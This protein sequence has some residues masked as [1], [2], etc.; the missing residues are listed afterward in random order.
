[1]NPVTVGTRPTVA[2]IGCGFGGV[3]TIRE[4]LRRGSNMIDILAL[5][6]S[7]HLY[8][9]PI[10]PRT[11]FED[12]PEH[13]VSVPLSGLLTRENVSLCCQRALK[14]DALRNVIETESG[15][16]PF[17]YCV[18]A[19]GAKAIPLKAAKNAPLFYPK[20]Q[21]HLSALRNWLRQ[22]IGDSAAHGTNDRSASVIRIAI[23]G[24]GLSGVEFAVALRILVQS[25]LGNRRLALDRVTITI[26]E[27]ENQIV[28]ECT[29]NLRRSLLRALQRW[30]VHVSLNHNATEVTAG[31]L[32]CN[33]KTIPADA[34]L[35]CTGSK[36]HTG[37]IELSGIPLH[38]GGILV[39]GSMRSVGQR[40]V[41][42]VGDV[43]CWQNSWQA[44][45]KRASEAVRQGRHVAHEIMAL[46][47]GRK[48]RRYRPRALTGVMLGPTHGLLAYQGLHISGWLPGV[49]KRVTEHAMIK[50]RG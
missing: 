49:L 37:H 28:P 14:V 25:E 16:R 30:D 46:F 2:V 1:M 48:P 42:A 10:V 45:T 11:L 17:D 44:N 39:D 38:R 43:L 13:H 34:V 3:A 26:Y 19:L 41:F 8:N 9:Y 18:I 23:A 27:R 35:C 40:N 21:R 20:S 7:P 4:L 12:V 33:A 50:A 15:S 6:S 5:N 32:V 24:G 29:S 47:G 31:G 22:R 36:P